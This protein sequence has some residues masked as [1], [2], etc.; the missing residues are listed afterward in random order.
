MQIKLLHHVLTM[1]LHRTNGDFQLGRDLFTG[2]AFRNAPDDLFLT[3]RQT[4]DLFFFFII[5][6]GS[7]K[8][9]NDVMR[10]L[11]TQEIRARMNFVDR[12]HDL[13]R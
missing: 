7:K 12:L 11:R 5:P 4:K 9:L 6:F 1:D 8:I 13:F 3:A 2:Q 10:Y